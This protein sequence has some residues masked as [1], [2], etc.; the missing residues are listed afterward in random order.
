MFSCRDNGRRHASYAMAPSIMAAMKLASTSMRAYQSSHL[1]CRNVRHSE[2]PFS[3][4]HRHHRFKM[5]RGTS[6]IFYVITSTEAAVAERAARCL[7]WRRRRRPKFYDHF[8]TTFAYIH[9]DISRP[10]LFDFL[11]VLH[12]HGTPQV[13]SRNEVKYIH[14]A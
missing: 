1:I 3:F 5:A 10:P 14:F 4:R 13:A 6:L 7:R 2:R 11:H 12:S 8:A 9:A